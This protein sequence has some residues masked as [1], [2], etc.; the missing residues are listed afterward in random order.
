MISIQANALTDSILFCDD[1]D[2]GLMT[3]FE[4]PAFP[5]GIITPLIQLVIDTVVM[6]M[7]YDSI[8]VVYYQVK[9]W[10]YTFI[11]AFLFAFG[12]AAYWW[13]I[14]WMQQKH[15]VAAKAASKAAIPA[16]PSTSVQAA[17]PS[18]KQS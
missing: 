6:Y 2:C 1:A 14:D 13:W 18:D 16:P 4:N 8:D 7:Y 17:A 10:Q 5:H 15:V 9:Y 11:R 3:L 12:G